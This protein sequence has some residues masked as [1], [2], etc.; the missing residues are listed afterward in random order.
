MQTVCSA[1]TG[2]VL[3]TVDRIFGSIYRAYTL[4]TRGAGR[5]PVSVPL[6]PG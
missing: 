1:E 6:E 2:R 3:M 5:H 4:I